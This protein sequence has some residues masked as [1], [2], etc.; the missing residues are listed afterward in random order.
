MAWRLEIH[1]ID[2]IGTG[3]ATLII[4]RE[5]PPLIGAA[6]LIRSALIDGGRR[7]HW[8]A[9]NAYITAQLGAAE[10]DV[11]I[12][13]HYDDDHVGGLI[14]LLLQPGTYDNTFI[15]DQGWPAPGLANNYI[16][17]VRAING[18]NVAGPVGGVAGVAARTRV[19]ARVRADGVAVPPLPGVLGALGPPAVPAGAPGTINRARSWLLN[20]AAAPAEILWNGAGVAAPAG[21]PTIRFIAANKFVT[22]PGGVVGPIGG[23]GVDP[24]NEKS[25]AIELTFGNF[26]YYVGGDIETAQENQI[27]L[28]LNPGDD[29]AGRL[30]AFKTSHHGANTATSRGF[31]DQLRPDAAFLS[32]GTG[33]A[34]F[35]PAQQTVNVLDGYP[36]FPAAHPP[37]PPLPP[38]RPVDYYLTGYQLPGP[39]PQT[40]GGDA[41]MTAGD[42]N[43]VPPVRGHIVLTVSAAQSAAPVEGTHYFAT[44]TAVNSALTAAAVAGAMGALAA[45]PVADAAAE[46]AMSFGPGGAAHD[47]IVQ[48]GGPMAAALAADGAANAALP[49]GGPATVMATAVAAAALGAG[50]VAAHAAG[51]GAA[52]GAFYAGGTPAAVRWAVRAALIAAGLAAAPAGAAGLAAQAAMPAT[53]S[54]FRVRLYDLLL[55]PAPGNTT[56]THR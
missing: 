39:P 15:Y 23:L 28:E 45:A 2:V 56:I 48:A 16:A 22:T 30:L 27:Q 26:R 8:A 7:L 34:H 9:L 50:A 41:S 3:D 33:N 14:D 20:G 54:Q 32:C 11:M 31:V 17:Y 49:A 5:V 38:N 55:M 44:Q 10:L 43:A 47:V 24:K 6:P 12:C 25:L 29:A 36:P 52:A 19:T 13:T 51:A 18:W 4:A 40:Y 42:P 53:P 37:V 46:A 35:H 21:A 1:H